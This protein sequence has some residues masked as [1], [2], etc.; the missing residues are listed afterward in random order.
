MS[1][2]E[3]IIPK[4]EKLRRAVRWV[5]E[6]CQSDPERKRLQVVQ[7][8]ELKFDLSPKESMFLYRTFQNNST[9]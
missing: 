5:G 6:I 8:A 1:Q 4:G 2:N 7:E 9:P 3:G